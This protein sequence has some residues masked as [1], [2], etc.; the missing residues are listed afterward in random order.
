MVNQVRGVVQSVALVTY[1]ATI[2]GTYKGKEV[3]SP[4]QAGEVW[5]KRDG[6]WIQASYQETPIDNN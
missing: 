2:R 4:V 6:K 5:V 1:R 3:P